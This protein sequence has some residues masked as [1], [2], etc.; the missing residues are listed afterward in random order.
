MNIEPGIIAA[1]AAA[2]SALLG[3][4]AA[5]IRAAAKMQE[6]RSEDEHTRN[7]WEQTTIDKQRDA[8]AAMMA[9]R[10]AASCR[11]LD[12]LTRRISDLESELK[13]LRADLEKRD[14][15]LAR[16]RTELDEAKRRIHQLELDNAKLDAQKTARDEQIVLLREQNAELYRMAADWTSFARQYMTRPEQGASAEQA[17]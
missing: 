15:E 14:A 16:V 9:E 6:A 12:L 1:L 7:L 3:A 8:M 10:D 11:E 5:S 17:A 13:R 4:W 2:V